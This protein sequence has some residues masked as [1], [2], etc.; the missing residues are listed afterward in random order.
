VK[1]SSEENINHSRSKQKKINENQANLFCVD[2]KEVEDKEGTLPV[3]NRMGCSGNPRKNLKNF[4]I[5]MKVHWKRHTQ[6][7]IWAL[8]FS[9]GIQEISLLANISKC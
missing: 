4:D 5:S 8:T 9:A 7:L 2:F 3:S 1:N 6:S